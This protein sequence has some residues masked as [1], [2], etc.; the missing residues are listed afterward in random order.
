MDTY[1]LGDKV[2]YTGLG[3]FWHGSACRIVGTRRHQS[4]GVIGYE[5]EQLADPNNRLFTLAR[6]LEPW[7]A[8]VARDKKEQ[9]RPTYW[10]EYHHYNGGKRLIK[11]FLHGDEEPPRENEQ[12]VVNA[13]TGE[14][15]V[16]FAGRAREAHMSGAYPAR[17]AAYLAPDPGDCALCGGCADACFCALNPAH[18]DNVS[19]TESD[20][21][22]NKIKIET[23]TFI[24]GNDAKKMS[25]SE[26]AGIIE[27]LQAERNRLDA[28]QRKPKPIRDRIIEIDNDLDALSA[29]FEDPTPEAE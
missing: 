8:P 17:R 1:K 3:P 22:D 21:M 7:D 2:R 23:I 24:N 27:R 11:F 16:T 13:P 25:T 26:L 19:S 10:G 9:L 15:T 12:F 14:K 28:L 29:L 20:D 4:S 5:I 6:L 18:P